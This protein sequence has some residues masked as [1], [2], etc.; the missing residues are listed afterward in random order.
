MTWQYKGLEFTETPDEYQGFV[1]EIE[2]I[3]TGK[4][5]IGKKNF[6]RV[7]KLPPLKGK[8]R[9]RHRR[10][11]TDWRDYYGSN[12]VLQEDIEIYG[13]ESV[14]RTILILCANRT[15]MSYFETKTQFDRNVLLDSRYYNDFIGCKI[16]GR[17][18]SSIEDV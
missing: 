6:W 7:D 9:R 14:N 3:A 10:T 13:P 4:L 5:Y 18:L 17:G 2:N 1:Y 11:Q 8:T 12:R 16:T 15:Q